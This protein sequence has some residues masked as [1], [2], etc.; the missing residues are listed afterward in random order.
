MN[1][2]FS[3]KFLTFFWIFC[4][5]KIKSTAWGYRAKSLRDFRG[6]MYYV[7][8]ITDHNDGGC[9][10]G[11]FVPAINEKGGPVL[12]PG[13]ANKQSQRKFSEPGVQN[14]PSTWHTG[15]AG[16]DAAASVDSSGK[17]KRDSSTGTTL[18]P[19]FSEHFSVNQK[20]SGF[21]TP[22]PLIPTADS[23]QIRKNLLPVWTDP[24]FPHWTPPKP[25]NGLDPLDPVQRRR[26]ELQ[27]F[28]EWY[29]A[30]DH[31]RI[32]AV[33]QANRE[34]QEV[35]EQLHYDEMETPFRRQ[36]YVKR[37]ISSP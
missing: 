30:R 12:V 37:L 26:K 28:R 35:K 15:A 16:V 5:I 32:E 7:I 36:E 21:D 33:R 24:Y 20:G 10:Q 29:L 4:E 22:I 2:R 1:F 11:N 13:F 6:Y 34:K 14:G 23:P 17:A 19:N 27:D 25:P 31:G 3:I 8:Y 18:F 9:C